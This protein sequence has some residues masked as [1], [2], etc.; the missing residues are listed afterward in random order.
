MKFKNIKFDKPYFIKSCGNDKSIDG[1]VIAY[2]NE[3]DSYGMETPDPEADV[4]VCEPL[5]IL[6]KQRLLIGGGKLYGYGHMSGARTDSNFL[7]EID[8]ENLID[9]TGDNFRCIDI[10]L[11]MEPVC[12]W[13]VVEINPPF[14]LDDYDIHLESYMEF[15]I[16][17]CQWINNQIH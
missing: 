12:K 13:I 15:C 1:K 7:N 8:I 9:I 16:D 5:T 14:S 6:S 17:A 10:G 4:Y 11:I 3:Y 2:A